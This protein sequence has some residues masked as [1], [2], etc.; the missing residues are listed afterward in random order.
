ML[1]KHPWEPFRQATGPAV[2]IANPSRKGK[3]GKSFVEKRASQGLKG[4]AQVSRAEIGLG[5]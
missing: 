2:I 4:R 3:L 5:W 1:L